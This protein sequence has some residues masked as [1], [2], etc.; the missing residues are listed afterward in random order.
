[1][2][3]GPGR[4]I[5][6]GGSGRFDDGEGRSAAGPIGSRGGDLIRTVRCI[7]PRA[8]DPDEL[9]GDLGFGTEDEMDPAGL[10]DEVAI[11][12]TG[13]D[14]GV[15]PSLAMELDEMLPVESED[16]PPF[17]DGMCQDVRIADAAPGHPRFLDRHDVVTEDSQFFD[18]REGEVLSA[19]SLATAQASSFSRI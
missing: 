8:V 2:A 4:S 18:D 12:G 14:A 9:V 7:W 13:H 11:A 15:F 5:R 19:K 10:R 6:A 16:R 1:V 3:D 17:L